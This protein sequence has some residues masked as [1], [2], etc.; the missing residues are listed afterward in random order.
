M[1]LLLKTNLEALT[2]ELFQTS[3]EEITNFFKKNQ[4]KTV[5]FPTHLARPAQVLAKA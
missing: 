5:C 3:K 1:N 2:G 4:G